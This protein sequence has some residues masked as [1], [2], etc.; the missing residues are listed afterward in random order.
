MLCTQDY[1]LYQG[2]TR[3]SLSPGD[4]HAPGAWSWWCPS[5]SS[6]GSALLGCTASLQWVEDVTAAS[7]RALTSPA[8]ISLE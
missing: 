8:G 1:I 2:R 3:E 4:V 6:V 7:T 5:A